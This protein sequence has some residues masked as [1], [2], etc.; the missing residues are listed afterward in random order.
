MKVLNKEYKLYIEIFYK[1][2][3]GY[4]NDKKKR[5]ISVTG[6]FYTLNKYGVYNLFM[7]NLK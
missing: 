5:T 1:E 6:L 4:V 7:V 3:T 2:I